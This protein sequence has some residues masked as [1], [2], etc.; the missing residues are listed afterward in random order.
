VDGIHEGMEG[1]PAVVVEDDPVI[2]ELVVHLLREEGL[3]ARGYGSAEAVVEDAAAM[4]AVLLVTD[5]ALPGRSGLDLARDMSRQNP[6]LAVV[7]VSGWIPE[8]S[9][10]LEPGWVCITKPFAPQRLSD[11][12]REVLDVRGS[13]R[14]SSS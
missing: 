13:Q 11:A 3:H 4:H 6:S 1:L 7:V 5:V 12:I 10:S 9:P 2:L 14:D 8:D